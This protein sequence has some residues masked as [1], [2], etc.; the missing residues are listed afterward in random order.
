MRLPL[1]ATLCLTLAFS[2]CKE[3]A[4]S[5]TGVA[6]ITPAADDASRLQNALDRLSAV[7]LSFEA[8]E[9]VK[10]QGGGVA[11]DRPALV[12]GV[13]SGLPSVSLLEDPALKPLLLGNDEAAL[14]KALTERGVQTVILQGRAAAALDRGLNV[15][16]RLYNHDQLTHFSL[17][18]VGTGGLL[19]YQVLSEPVTFPPEIANLCVQYLTA[20]L[21]GN[22]V[23]GFPTLEDDG[24]WTLMATVRGQGRE[25]ATAFALNKSLQG[26]LEE[27]VSD[28]ERTHRRGAEL[29]GFLPINQAIDDLTIEVHRVVERATIEPRDE[30]FLQDY[31]EMG[32]D[33]AYILTTVEGKRERAAISGAVSYTRSLRTADHFLRE[34]AQIGG[35]TERRPWRAEGAT[36]ESLRTLHY[37]KMPKGPLLPMYRGAP[38]ISTSLVTRAATRE[39]LL[40]AGD[41]Y[42]QN[43]GP[44]GQVVY[45]FWPTENRYSD[46][47][48]IV[49][50]T[51]A[52]WNLVQAWNLDQ[53]RADF[54]VGAEANFQF[55]QKFLKKET[56][57]DG[58][59][60]TYYVHQQNIKLG[61]VVVQLLG[62]IDLARAKNDHQWD[63]QMK[64]MGRFI[65]FMQEPSGTF[66]GYHVPK[67]HP[68]ENQKNDIIPGE[69]ALALATL[70]TYFN[71]PAWIATLPRYWDY[72]YTWFDE[73]AAKRKE[74]MPWPALIYDNNDRLDLV[75]MGP[76]TVMAAYEYYKHTQDP[77]VAA[78]GLRI[79][80]WMID[81]Y[82]WD[83]ARA[84][85]PD[86]VGGYYKFVGELPAMQAFCYGEG[87]AAAYK[88]A[89][90]AKPD[91]AAYF[92]QRTRE[93]VRF[94]MQMSFDPTNT[95]AFSRPEQVD[96]GI[97]YAMN[98]PKVRID[99]V[100]HAFS[101]MYQWYEGAGT[102]AA[103]A[104]SVKDGPLHPLQLW[105]LDEERK[106]V[107]AARPEGASPEGTPPADV[108]WQRKNRFFVPYYRPDVSREL[109]MPG[110]AMKARD[111]ARQSGDDDEAKEPAEE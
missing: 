39:T 4:T 49:R 75:Q 22:R 76:W 28:I 48:N 82:M 105:R 63:E 83:S 65:L 51:L 3:G 67:G 47:Y 7:S 57:P 99:Y 26:S 111:G 6:I 110:E 73:R 70:A 77:K 108:V 89:L 27:L 15:Q 34:A 13:P 35:M 44:D 80:R 21:K 59:P 9:R 62:L 23:T 69:A 29:S 86:Y 66:R 18:R 41:W 52:T 2:A 20:R 33:G 64:E 56:G 61:T 16:T 25:M 37:M 71:D 87:T 98:E 84:P 46:E 107:E 85:F 96:G 101:A 60:M 102:D 38:L 19:V 42:L 106:A 72:F 45:K 78:F 40:R 55:T 74:G 53:R 1:L 100:Y 11:I 5:S 79:A 97:R 12:Q 24:T 43:M 104:A 36:L 103:L 90:V 95:Y 17:S 94:G 91:E 31:W 32:I 81:S 58:K 8:A 109:I 14:A 88:L 92:E 10:K 30:A 50:H 54:L 68:Y 93:M